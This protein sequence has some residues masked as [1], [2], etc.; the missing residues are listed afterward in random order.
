M[1]ITRQEQSG[2]IESHATWVSFLAWFRDLSTLEEAQFVLYVEG[3][4]RACDEAHVWALEWRQE[5]VQ[6]A[7]ALGF[8]TL[9]SRQWQVM[10]ARAEVRVIG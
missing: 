8:A 7:M 3:E 4:I 9:P 5:L 6:R 2:A 10:D 1:P